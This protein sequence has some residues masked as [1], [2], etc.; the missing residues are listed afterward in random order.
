MMIQGLMTRG[1]ERDW[2]DDKYSLLLRGNVVN[3]S[4][5]ELQP[6]S[7]GPL[8]PA[9]V[10]RINRAAEVRPVRLRV[11]GGTNSPEWVKTLAKAFPY[12]E[13]QG[14]DDYTCPQWWLDSYID[15]WEELQLRLYNVAHDAV[16]EVCQTGGG[17]RYGE[18]F[19]RGPWT[20]KDE[21]R[22]LGMDFE[23]DSHALD[24]FYGI[25]K[26]VWHDTPIVVALYKWQF[27]E[28]GRPKASMDRAFE[29]VE[30]WNPDI[31]GTHNFRAD[32]DS[33]KGVYDEM[34]ATGK[35]LYYQTA[36]PARFKDWEGGL[37]VGLKYGARS[38]E[39][40]H[41]FRT[42]DYEKLAELA[43]QYESLG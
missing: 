22:R 11:L 24:R 41:H 30:R 25:A 10:D 43:Y 12:H 42:F 15:A 40:P 39:L 6:K 2:K 37:K 1:F 5:S 33:D 34:K 3:L 31:I 19:I 13:D 18:I 23:T 36:E 21:Y 14:D 20:N 9:A 35:R 38:V 27:M 4:W 32:Y 7:N 26:N 16:S 8:A 29:A 17:T 28:D